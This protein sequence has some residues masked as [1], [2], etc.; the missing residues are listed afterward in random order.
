MVSWLQQAEQYKGEIPQD[1]ISEIFHANIGPAKLYITTSDKRTITIQPAF[2]LASK[3]GKSF[4]KRYITDVL[5]LSNDKQK[6]YVQSGE[7]FNWL[8]NNKWESE[9]RKK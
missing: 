4:E 6:S 5:Q 3:D 7:L 1:Q 8:K 9:M 2:Y